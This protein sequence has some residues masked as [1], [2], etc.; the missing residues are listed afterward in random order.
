MD[1]GDAVN[2]R[3]P[4]DVL[5]ILGPTL[6]DSAIAGVG[7]PELQGL[8]ELVGAVVPKAVGYSGAGDGAAEQGVG[9]RRSGAKLTGEMLGGS[10]GVG[11]SALRG[12]GR[13]P[14]VP[15]K[16]S[17]RGL[18]MGVYAPE[19]RTSPGVAMG[20]VVQKN[21]KRSETNPRKN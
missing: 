3:P 12:V 19:R 7:R 21:S 14:R 2:S 4:D 16:C 18:G 13:A 5:A 8:L 1:R 20:S 11:V 6:D 9:I 10:A 15:G 17:G